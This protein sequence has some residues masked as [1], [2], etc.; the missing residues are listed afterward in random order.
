M[1]NAFIIQLIRTYQH[2]NVYFG[3]VVPYHQVE[4][5]VNHSVR[6]KGDNRVTR[7]VGIVLALTAHNTRNVYRI[8]FV[9]SQFHPDNITKFL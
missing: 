4:E 6:G 3:Q 7:S 1:W 2:S 8:S 9:M 5:L